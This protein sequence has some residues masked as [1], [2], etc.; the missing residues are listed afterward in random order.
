MNWLLQRVVSYARARLLEAS[1]WRNLILLVG[2]SS[3]AAHP[4]LVAAIVP[5]CIALAGAIGS[6]LP[7]F[8]GGQ[9]KAKTDDPGPTLP[10]IELQ[11]RAD[12]ASAD[13]AAADR[14]HYTVPAGRLF[15]PEHDERGGDAGWNG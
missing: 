11:G 13:A 5:V 12:P 2:G 8:L 10:P 6:F 3:A 4:E 9:N 7:D 15:A 14:L 1:T